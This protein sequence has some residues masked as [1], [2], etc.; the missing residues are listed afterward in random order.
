MSVR[1]MFGLV[2]VFLVNAFVTQLNRNYG[3][4]RAHVRPHSLTRAFLVRLEDVS[5]SQSDW[6]I[7]LLERKDVGAA[8]D[9]ALACFYAPRIVVNYK[10][11]HKDSLEYKFWKWALTCFHSADQFDARIG[12]YLGFVSRA[13]SRLDA[14]SFELSKESLLLGATVTGR[15]ELVGVVE[16]SLEEPCG[17][18]SPPF[19]NPFQ[20]SRRSM[21]GKEQPYLCNLCVSPSYRRQGLGKLLCTLA[22]EIVCSHWPRKCTR[23]MFIH[24]EKRNSAARCLYNQLGYNETIDVDVDY[25]LDK[26]ILYFAKDISQ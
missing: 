14:P 18:L 10:G 24:V 3:L 1:L 13:W 19:V 8:A 11:M 26:D 6:D 21:N 4:S 16:V 23:K 7:H 25:T 5:N 22:K 17:R 20:R 9:L 12:N 15:T 2:L